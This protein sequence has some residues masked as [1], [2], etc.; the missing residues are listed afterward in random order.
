MSS[1]S[2]A[3]ILLKSLVLAALLLAGIPVRAQTTIDLVVSYWD[4]FENTV[5]K[6]STITV[7]MAALGVGLFQA[8]NGAHRI[9]KVTVFTDGAMADRADIVW[10][11]DKG[12]DGNDCWFN[13]HVG[14]RGKPGARIQHCD[15][16]GGNPDAYSML[17]KKISGGF[18]MAHEMGHYFYALYDEYAGSGDC[19]ASSG[20]SP[21]GQDIAVQGSIMNNTWIATDQS[22]NFVNPAALSFSTSKNNTGATNAQFRAY[23]ASAWDT[24]VRPIEQDPVG[25]GQQR[26]FFADLVAAAPPAGQDPPVVVQMSDS[27]SLLRAL[28]AASVEFKPGSAS[29]AARRG[30]S[31]QNS[32]ANTFATASGQIPPVRILAVD[33]STSTSAAELTMIKSALGD[34]VRRT[35][36]GVRLALV[37]LDN[38]ATVAVAP[39]TVDSGAPPAA[40]LAAIHALSVS[41]KAP[42]LGDALLSLAAKLPSFGLDQRSTQSLYLF[43]NGFS[44]SGSKVADGGAALRTAG[45]TVF[46]FGLSSADET[47][48]TTLHDLASLTRGESYAATKASLLNEALQLADEASSPGVDVELLADEESLSGTKDHPFMIEA[49]ISTIEVAVDLTA[50]LSDVS[51]ALVD[52]AGKVTA[53]SC[54]AEDDTVAGAQDLQC[55]LTQDAPAA[56]NWKL[57]IAN[58]GSATEVMYSVI[59]IPASNVGT[60]FAETR[61]ERRAADNRVGNKLALTANVGGDM[62]ITGIT[63]TTTVIEPD[64]NKV[65]VQMLDA[66]AAPDL[67]AADGVYSASFTP[68]KE[69]TYSIHTQFDNSAGTGSFSNKGIS[70]VPY[71]GGGTPTKGLTPTSKTFVRSARSEFQV[72]G[73]S[74]DYDRVMNWAE[75]KL[76]TI[77]PVAQRTATTAAPLK[78]RTYSSSGNTISYNTE[79]GQFY[80]KAKEFGTTAVPIGGVAKWL[81]LAAADKY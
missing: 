41:S 14:G 35:E 40:L 34:L 24:L 38:T 13:A 9:G 30:L 53:A 37:T 10:R 77:F 3:R 20:G 7:S 72:K 49:G 61:M 44:A 45:L 52:P 42:A 36:P 65:V 29:T 6:Q 32:F 47:S 2:N 73:V 16:G 19:T 12:D 4:S 8:T 51:V 58:Q 23:G 28:A 64:G 21:C 69:G 27:A 31:R 25:S 54:A 81:P 62:P 15:I 78:L 5:A 55:T 75:F 70:Y 17:T 1:G 76:P 74:P 48:S 71:I 46:G 39:I 43:T 63:V 60:M 11:K 18:V 66:G 22:D 79:D 50:K 80:V 56:G 68:T 67:T 26:T 33:V 57:R 59:G